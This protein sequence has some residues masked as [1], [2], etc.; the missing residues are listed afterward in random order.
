MARLVTFLL[1]PYYSYHLTPS[2]YGEVTLYYIFMGVAQTFFVYGLDIAYLR[3]FTMESDPEEKK[4]I[5]GTTIWTS[6]ISSASLTLLLIVSARFIGDMLIFKPVHPEIVPNMIRLCAGIMF[7]DTLVTFPY[8]LLRGSHRP[9]SFTAMKAI[10]VATN[11]GLNIW[12][13]GSLNLGVSGILWANIISSAFTLLLLMP[14]LIKS[15]ALVIDKK[16][17]AEM[18]RFGIP[19]I[20]TY[21]FVM[22]VELADRKFL[23]YYRGLDESGLYSA[24]YKLG[25]FMAVVTAAFRFAWQPFFLS[26]AKEDNAPRLFARVLTY[27]LTITGFLFLGLSFF[28]E[29]IIHHKWPTIGFI[30]D[31]RFWPGLAVFPVILLAHIFDGVYANLMV[32]V[33][34]KKL[35][36]KLPAVTGAAAL[37]TIVGNVLFVPTWGM[38]AAA[39][40]TLIAFVM[41]AVLLWVVVRKEYVVPYEWQ[42]ML[43]LCIC[44]GVLFGISM[45]PIF[46]SWWLRLIILAIFPVALYVIRF[47]DDRELFYLRKVIPR[48]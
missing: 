27:Y 30:I 26:H 43:K 2:E 14:D 32:G 29:P 28:V 13:V 6:L 40:I 39:Y 22:V 10:N 16:L 11:I 25:M 24:G 47:F 44:I 38:W 34:V 21:L 20:P 48:I 41:Q 42:R 8:L 3:Y 33:Y 18:I 5:T 19:N 31:S 1:L 36:R 35:T 7:F 37:F 12:F 45:I 46:S 23:E 17:L 4:R 15:G 9:F